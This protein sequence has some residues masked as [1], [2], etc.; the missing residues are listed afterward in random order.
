M[1]Q[2]VE[3]KDE[4]Q[5]RR[6]LE[7]PVHIY[8]G[9]P[10]WIRPLDKDVNEVFNP[11]KN[12]A[13]RSGEVI[14]WLLLDE[15]QP[16]GRIAAFVN[17]RYKNKGDQGPVG[18]VGFFECINNQAAANLL[19]DQAR[20]WLTEKQ[21]TAMDGPINFG[22]RDKWW[23]LLVQGFQQPLYCMNYNAP[24]Y[25]ALFENYGFQLFYQQICF[26][27]HPR[28]PFQEKLFVRHAQIEKD[29]HFSARYMSKKDIDQ[30]AAD[31]CTVYNKAWAKH[32]GNKEL[33]LQQCKLMFRSMKPVIDERINWFVYYK[34]EP[35]AIF[36]NLPDLNQWFKYLNGK[37]GLLQK[38]R[39]LWLKRFKVNKRFVGL[40][41]G[42][43]PEWQGKGV[44]SYLIVEAGKIVQHKLH[45]DEYEMQWIGDF[46]PKMIAVAETLT[47]IRSRVLTTYRYLFDRNQAFHR[48]PIL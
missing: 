40:V 2:L 24:Y 34:D 4:K 23:G 33:T 17:K 14:R 12:K 35:I 16:I 18:G 3:V 28:E 20:E 31:F 13:F 22:E 25:Q 5:A 21:V 11:A 30:Y 10:N 45:Y 19:F 38:L 7:V 27:M 41:F 47:P 9:N 8:K 37:F 1:M 6:F 46:N 26:G 39:F 42:V 48:H 43:V 36:I 15:G 29:P 32:A 44:D